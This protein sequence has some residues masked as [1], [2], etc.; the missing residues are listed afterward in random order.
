MSPLASAAASGGG[1]GGGLSSL[2]LLLPLLLLAYLFY[3]QRKR[4]KKL[5]EVQ[6]SLEIGQRVMTTTGLFGTVAAL[7]ETS[8]HI[9]AAP[10]VVLQWDRRAVVPAQGAQPPHAQPGEKSEGDA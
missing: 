10:G 4:Q 5:Q 3:A 8:V 1:G 2:L 7:D 9:E 6:A